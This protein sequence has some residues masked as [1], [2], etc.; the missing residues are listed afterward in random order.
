MQ[1]NV[2]GPCLWRSIHVIALGYPRSP[3]DEVRQNFKDF[4]EN[5]WKVIPCPKCSVNYRRHLQELAPIDEFLS[6]PD[7]L[8]AWTVAMHNIVNNELGKRQYSVEEAKQIHSQMPMCDVKKDSHVKE[9]GFT[10]HI[11]LISILILIAVIILMLYKQLNK[12]ILLQ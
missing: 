3:S 9:S 1:P 4:Y 5:F 11:S 6:S 10:Q 8:F 2:W 12:N 7:D